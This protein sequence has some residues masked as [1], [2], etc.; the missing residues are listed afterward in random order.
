MTIKVG[1][2]PRFDGEGHA[3]LRRV[4]RFGYWYGVD[5]LP[6][7]MPEKLALLEAHCEREGRAIKDVQTAVSPYANACDR[8]MLKC[9]EDAGVHQVVLAAFVPGQDAMERA[10]DDYAKALL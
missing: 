8:D 2:M 5:V 1:V 10:I 6:E 3:A 7:H 4:A 9:Y